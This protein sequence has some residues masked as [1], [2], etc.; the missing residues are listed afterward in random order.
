M[1]DYSTGKIAIASLVGVL[2]V[3]I[4]VLLLVITPKKQENVASETKNEIT[5]TTVIPDNSVASTQQSS[6]AESQQ[7]IFV[8]T[9]ALKVDVR[10]DNSW[11]SG[12]GKSYQYT[13]KITNA[14]DV[15]ISGWNA[16]LDFGTN[17]T[18]DTSL[19]GTISVSDTG[20]AIAPVDYN[21]EIP[22]GGSAEVGIIITAV[23]PV[24]LQVGLN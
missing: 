10:L 3:S 18:L 5:E 17:F 9:G 12:T 13:I 7:P 20:L 22:A 15:A 24:E 16:W 8:E 1:K 23:S 2:L 11:E 19:N 4:I 21:Y 6:E 14:G